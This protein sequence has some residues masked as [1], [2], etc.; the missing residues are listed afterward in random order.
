MR[1]LFVTGTGTG[2][3]KTTVTAAL[4]RALVADGVPVAALKPIETGVDPIAADARALADAAGDPSL[5]DDPRWYRTRPPLAPYAAT[6]EGEPAPDLASLARA[7][8]DRAADRYALVEGAG[9]LL[10]PLDR[11]HTIADLALALG[12]PIVLVAPDRLGVLSD[13]LAT[14]EAAR[15]RGLVVRALV[16]SQV[17]PTTDRSV[18]TNAGILAELTKTPVISFG[19]GASTS[20]ALRALAR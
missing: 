10:V 20:P 16:L 9:G 4:A 18:R 12:L 1:G 2:A 6:L 14:L 15:A 13:A 3:G 11:E 5:A 8:R 19:Y 7:V 17:A